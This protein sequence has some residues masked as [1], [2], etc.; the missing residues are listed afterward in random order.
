MLLIVS[1]DIS[2]DIVVTLPYIAV[3]CIAVDD[4][5]AT[6]GNSCSSLFTATVLLLP[7]S[8]R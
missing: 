8:P 1:L 4:L 5:P 3:E 2:R 7:D 6:E